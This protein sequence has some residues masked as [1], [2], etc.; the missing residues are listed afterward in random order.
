MTTDAQ[1]NIKNYR[2]NMYLTNVKEAG[3]SAMY[4][5]QINVD[6]DIKRQAMLLKRAFL[7][8]RNMHGLPAFGSLDKHKQHVLS[9]CG[10]TPIEVNNGSVKWVREVIDTGVSFKD[11]VEKIIDDGRVAKYKLSVMHVNVDGRNFAVC[12]SKRKIK[13]VKKSTCI[14]NIFE[15]LIDAVE[16]YSGTDEVAKYIYSHLINS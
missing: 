4:A 3:C 7:A 10:V 11:T 6:D 12:V 14:L 8:H 5:H 16:P 1:S 9:M 13:G 2:Y 15:L